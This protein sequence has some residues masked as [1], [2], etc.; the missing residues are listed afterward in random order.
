MPP[1]A[2]QLETTEREVMN[3]PEQARALLQEPSAMGVK[4]PMDDFGSAVSSLGGLRDCPFETIENLGLI[5]VAGRIED[6]AEVAVLQ[7]IGCRYGQS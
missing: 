4:L 5:S 2:L 3:N 1:S 6:P 7:A